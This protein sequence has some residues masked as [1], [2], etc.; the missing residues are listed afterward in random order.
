MYDPS[1]KKA[2]LSRDAK[3]CESNFENVA[4][5]RDEIREESISVYHNF[6]WEFHVIYPYNIDDDNH[7]NIAQVRD[8]DHNHDNHQ[9][10]EPEGDTDV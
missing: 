6:E 9:D 2:I 8:N 1:T 7:Q 5:A 4:N 3:F 10:I